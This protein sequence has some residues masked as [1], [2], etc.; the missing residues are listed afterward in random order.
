M[1]Y[2]SGGEVHVAPPRVARVV[3]AVHLGPDE[4]VD[5]RPEG[6]ARVRVVEHAE[7]DVGRRPDEQRVL[8]DAEHGQRQQVDEAVED[9][10]ERV[11]AHAGQEVELRRAVV[12]LVQPPPPVPAVL[13]PVGHVEEEVQHHEDD[14]RLREHGSPASRPRPSGSR[15]PPAS[16][17]RSASRKLI[18]TRIA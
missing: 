8:R 2:S 16:V 10:V 6:D 5:Q 4:D 7:E 9:L 17:R 14:R 15:W 3:P 11:E 13:E 18:A 12:G 1:P